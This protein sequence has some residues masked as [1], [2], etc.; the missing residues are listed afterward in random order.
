[1]LRLFA[2]RRRE[3]HG[4]TLVETLIAIT[5]IFGALVM[6]AYTATIGFTYQRVARERQA[7]NGIA[8]QLAEEI[9]GLAYSKVQSGLLTSGLAS[10]PNLVTSC[11]G[12]AVGTYRLTNCAGEKVV[13]ST[14]L[15]TTVPLVPKK[16]SLF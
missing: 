4:F 5:V 11:A 15:P 7:A 1:M 10:D 8:N 2:A 9:R 14:G 6:L 3:Q 13:S 12:D 16:V